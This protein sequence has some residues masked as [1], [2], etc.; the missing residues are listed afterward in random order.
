M[1][2]HLN[3]LKAG[4]RFWGWGRMGNDRVPIMG[5]KMCKGSTKRAW[6]EAA[7]IVTQCD[8]HI[9]HYIVNSTSV[10]VTPF[11]TL[12]YSH[13]YDIANKMIRTR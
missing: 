10:I 5:C 12:R 13:F 9:S 2:S 11:I 3:I 6:E 8:S 4:L 1:L 7:H